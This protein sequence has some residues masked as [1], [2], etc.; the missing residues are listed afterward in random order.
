MARKK[1]RTN[2]PKPGSV[3]TTPNPSK[4]EMG[5]KLEAALQ[6]AND[7]FK[8]ITDS[9]PEASIEEVLG[10]IDLQS[11]NSSSDVSPGESTSTEGDGAS[12][13]FSKTLKEINAA[14]SA[15][16]KAVRTA[17]S[18]ERAAKNSEEKSKK[19]IENYTNKIDSLDERE[20]ALSEKAEENS[21]EEASILLK[22][23]ELEESKKE[24]QE[25]EESLV[26]RE[27]DADAGFIARRAEILSKLEDEMSSYATKL[28]KHGEK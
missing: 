22:I 7:D 10:E 25:R 20:K 12:I 13:D 2:K 16:A 23:E 5:A 4:N 26:S 9:I 19:T 8:K 21:E 27:A 3:K 28:A 15:L 14:R 1:K 6:G 18:R 17:E 24:F 11:K